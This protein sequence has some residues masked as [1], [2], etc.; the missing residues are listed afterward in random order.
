M[1]G[2]QGVTVYENAFIFLTMFVSI[3]YFANILETIK[4]LIGELARQ[5]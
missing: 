4:G 1:L 5:N 3:S 2:T